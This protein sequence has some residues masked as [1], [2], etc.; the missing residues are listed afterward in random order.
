[1]TFPENYGAATGRPARLRGHVKEVAAPEEVA[2]DDD[3]AKQ[4]RARMPREL[5]EAMRSSA[6]RTMRG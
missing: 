5:K 2:V 1:M 3:L 4:A 6:V